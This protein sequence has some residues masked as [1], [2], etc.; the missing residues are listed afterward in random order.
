MAT[1]ETDSTTVT[2]STTA[3]EVTTLLHLTGTDPK[4]QADCLSKI[5]GP[6]GEPYKSATAVSTFT[7]VIAVDM[8]L[9]TTS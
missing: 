5:A 8:V 4:V 6:N 3:T 7:V 1:I 9:V 2:V